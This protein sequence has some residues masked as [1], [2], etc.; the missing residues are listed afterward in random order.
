MNRLKSKAAFV[1]RFDETRSVIRRF[2]VRYGLCWVVL[3]LACGLILLAAGDYWFEWSRAIRAVGLGVVGCIALVVAAARILAPIVWWSRPHTAIEIEQH[4]PQLGQRVRTVVQFSGQ[5]DEAVAAEG[6]SPNLVTALEEETDACARPLDLRKVIPLWR[7]RMAALTAGVLVL[8]LVCGVL[9][10]WETRVAT[11]RALLSDRPYTTLAVTP[12]DVLID[13]GKD[14][15]VSIELSGNV[16]RRVVL[17]TRRTDTEGAGWQQREL[18]ADDVQTAGK[19]TMEYEAELKEVAG[20]TEYRAVAGPAESDVYCVSV[21][22]PLAITKFEATLTPPAYTGV[23]AKI[24]EGGDLD[25]IEGS[26]VR[27][28]MEFDRPT[29]EAALFFTD[30]RYKNKEGEVAS[31]PT[32]V[33]LTLDGEAFV[34]DMQFSDD[35]SYEIVATARE[36]VSL[37]TNKYRVRV[38]KDRAPR[39]RFES[40]AEALEV[41]SIAE[42]LMR[43]HTSDDFGLTKAGIVFQ[44]NNGEEQTLFV[45]DFPAA[46]DRESEADE[47]RT[48][49]TAVED[50]LL[51]E[52]C[53][54]T[55]TDSVTYYAFA[56]DSFPDAAK[57][58]ETD[59]RFIDIRPF[60]RIYKKGGT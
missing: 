59:L 42:L 38:Q 16:D 36:G 40:P 25:V 41:H 30:P 15:T 9:F 60:K 11:G 6:V 27:F 51:L 29:A 3:V 37:P 24:V 14:V 57:R 4:F 54:L 1:D 50:M 8:G 52:Q 20:P 34:A 17:H 31:E 23:K 18:T 49:H 47:S 2:Q 43:I 32:P 28:R 19:H 22:Y 10:N 58:T 21:R 7:L 35:K 26:R 53:N 46:D 44:V 13:Q 33:P 55:P 48:V 56:E 39:V 45:K 12:G 5:D